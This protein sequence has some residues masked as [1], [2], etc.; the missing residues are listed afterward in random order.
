[1][2]QQ[3]EAAGVSYITVHGR[4]PRQRHEAVD[5]ELF[6]VAKDSVNIPV[7]ANGDVFSLEDARRLKVKCGV[8]GELT[9]IFFIISLLI[10]VKKYFN[11]FAQNNSDHKLM[12]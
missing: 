6:C 7:I 4:T 10:L 3:A 1:M 2:C 11:I 12:E 8:D 5:E 9:L